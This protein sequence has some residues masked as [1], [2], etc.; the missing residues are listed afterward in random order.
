M[1]IN[2]NKIYSTPKY[3]INFKAIK[4]NEKELLESKKL[5]NKY[6]KAPEQELESLKNKTFKFFEKHLLEE[7][8]L[9]TKSYHIKLLLV[10]DF[11][12]YI[13]TNCSKLFYNF[14]ITAVN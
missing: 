3:K 6:I 13:H 14:F 1:N 5:L 12:C 7:I 8:N 2:N 9:K 11:A 10:K 4:L